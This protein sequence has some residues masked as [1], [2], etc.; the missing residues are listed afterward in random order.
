MPS[1]FLDS[2]LVLFLQ[3]CYVIQSGINT[4]LP[5]AMTKLP[6][7]SADA[8]RVELRFT[9]FWAWDVVWM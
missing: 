7:S 2:A 8:S 5:E 9:Q 6:T 4:V 1:P 3:L